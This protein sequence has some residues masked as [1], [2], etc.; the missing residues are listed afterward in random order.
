MREK[1]NHEDNQR[2]PQRPFRLAEDIEIWKNEMQTKIGIKKEAFHP[3]DLI[4]RF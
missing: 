2:R 1:K 4:S 3:S